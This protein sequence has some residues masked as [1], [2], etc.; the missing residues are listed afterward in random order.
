[1][2]RTHWR[3]LRNPNYIGAYSLDPDNPEL[4]LTINNVTK[5]SVKDNKGDAT[6]CTVAYF[7][8]DQKPMILNATNCRTIA[9]LYGSNYIEEWA[10]A[11]ITLYAAQVKAFGD[12]VE[13]LRIRD[14]RPTQSL[15]DLNPKHKKW[16]AAKTAIA[17][18]NTT[19][20]AIRKNYSLTP[21]NEKLLCSK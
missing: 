13:A 16:E 6:D 18:K 11:K 5:E 14:K 10:G 12:T 8:E 7:K 15:P 21:E 3:L 4:T 1:M 19:V 20:Q 9:K 17:K 2:K